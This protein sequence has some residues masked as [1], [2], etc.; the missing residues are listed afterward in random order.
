MRYTKPQITGVYSA[1]TA[2][3]TIKV[4]PLSEADTGFPTDGNGYQADE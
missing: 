1:L 2:I 3:K 4:E